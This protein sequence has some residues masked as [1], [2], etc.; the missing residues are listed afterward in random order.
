MRGVGCGVWN[1]SS[2]PYRTTPLLPSA[3]LTSTQTHSPYQEESLTRQHSGD[4]VRGPWGSQ[5]LGR[6]DHQDELLG[7]SDLTQTFSNFMHQD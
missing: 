3:W 6:S 7:T 1:G 4:D 5:L 2:P